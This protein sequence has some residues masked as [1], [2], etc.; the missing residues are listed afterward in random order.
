MKKVSLFPVLKTKVTETG[1]LTLVMLPILKLLEQVYW[2]LSEQDQIFI[3][4]HRVWQQWLYML[5]A[6]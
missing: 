3:L 1:K 5:L 4:G 2:K 6:A